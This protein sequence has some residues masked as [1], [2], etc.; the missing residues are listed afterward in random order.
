ME[1]LNKLEERVGKL[2]YV[3][4]QGAE[5]TVRKIQEEILNDLYKLREALSQDLKEGNA[6]TPTDNEPLLKE[7]KQLKEENAK[8]HYRISHLKKHIE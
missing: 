8:L 7:I 3:F 2:E 6:G 4:G 1:N 5:D